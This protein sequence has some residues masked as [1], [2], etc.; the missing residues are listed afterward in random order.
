SPGYIAMASCMMQTIARITVIGHLAFKKFTVSKAAV[1]VMLNERVFPA[2]ADHLLVYKR[3]Q[4]FGAA[5]GINPGGTNI[6]TIAAS[7]Q[8]NF[9]LKSAQIIARAYV[10]NWP[11]A[12]ATRRCYR[13]LFPAAL[14]HHGTGETSIKGHVSCGLLSLGSGDEH[15]SISPNPCCLFAADRCFCTAELRTEI[16]AD[17]RTCIRDQLA[18]SNCDQEVL[19]SAVSGGTAASRDMGDIHKRPRRLRTAFTWQRRRTRFDIA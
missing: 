10:I 2:T 17:H 8:L 12:T 19:P 16:G 1:Q 6:T 3:S 13:Q 5:N 18:T 4:Q 11:Q 7:A 15:A 14:Q 9:A